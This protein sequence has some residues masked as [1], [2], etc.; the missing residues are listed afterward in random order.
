LVNGEPALISGKRV[1]V[2]ALGTLRCF[3][4]PNVEGNDD[5]R[6]VIYA[7]SDGEMQRFAGKLDNAGMIQ[8]VVVCELPGEDSFDTA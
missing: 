7:W 4:V 8:D 6:C 2:D 5:A 3:L 1:D